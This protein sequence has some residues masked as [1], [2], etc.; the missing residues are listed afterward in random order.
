MTAP[1]ATPGTRGA[2]PLPP[3]SPTDQNG[4]NLGALGGYGPGGNLAPGNPANGN[5]P[6]GGTTV[7][8]GQAGVAPQQ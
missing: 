8:Q 7:P 6:R 1:N 4:N 5:P 3:P 2:A